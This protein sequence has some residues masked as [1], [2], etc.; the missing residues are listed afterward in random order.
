MV[1]DAVHM[2]PVWRLFSLQTGKTTGNTRKFN[3]SKGQ[4]PKESDVTS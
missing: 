4:K 2:K 3:L 1:P